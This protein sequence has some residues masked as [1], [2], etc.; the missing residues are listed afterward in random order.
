MTDRRFAAP[1]AALS[2]IRARYRF[3]EGDTV[4][5]PVRPSGAWLGCDR[6]RQ[7]ACHPHTKAGLRWQLVSDTVLAALADDRWL[8]AQLE[9]P[10]YVDVP[11]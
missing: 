9:A 2:T 3:I 7:R 8:T 4:S 10:R 5:V 11:A 1:S 6:W